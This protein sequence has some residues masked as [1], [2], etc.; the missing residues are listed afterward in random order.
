MFKE[1]HGVYTCETPLMGRE[2]HDCVQEGTPVSF[3]E[4]FVQEV[5]EHPESLKSWSRKIASEPSVEA[6]ERHSLAQSSP[7][8]ER[9]RIFLLALYAD[10]TQFSQRDSLLVFTA[11]MLSSGTRRLELA[12]SMS[13]MCDC[14]CGGLCA[15]FPLYRFVVWSLVSPASDKIL[16]SRHE[17]PLWLPSDD[18]RKLHRHGIQ[19][20]RHGHPRSKA[21][22]D[23][24]ENS[25]CHWAFVL[26]T[27]WNCRFSWPMSWIMGMMQNFA[28]MVLPW[29]SPEH[30]M[31]H[32]RH[33]LR[34]VE[35]AT[36]VDECSFDV[37]IL[38]D[39]TPR[40][41]FAVGGLGP[42]QHWA[43]SEA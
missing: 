41:L 23:A 40:A 21:K 22:R 8:E 42:S 43:Q 17:G 1:D 16:A 15:L 25:T 18:Q 5:E 3:H 34:S 13:S 39:W 32:R 26:V 31:V 4:S 28:V 19:V 30:P 33:P 37:G 6:Y 2:E 35:I 27:A 12:V 10:A 7:R 20:R 9:T 38:Q 29:R 36:G 14:G 11:H 24:S